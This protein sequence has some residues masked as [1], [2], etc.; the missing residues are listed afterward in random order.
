[1]HTVRTQYIASTC[2]ASAHVVYSVG[3][4]EVTTSVLSSQCIYMVIMHDH[5]HT[6]NSITVDHYY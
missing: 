3:N 5:R 4:N 1:M 2:T 6:N